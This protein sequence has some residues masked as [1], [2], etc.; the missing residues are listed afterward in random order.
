[1][2]TYD[3]IV[4]NDYPAHVETYRGFLRGVRLSV[5]AGALVLI[6]LAYFLL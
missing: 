6:L 2:V 5:G 3:P 4:D 1:M